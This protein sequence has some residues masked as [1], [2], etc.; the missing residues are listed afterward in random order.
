MLTDISLA[1]QVK[2]TDDVQSGDHSWTFSS[3]PFTLS[4]RHQ[5]SM[6]GMGSVARIRRVRRLGMGSCFGLGVVVVSSVEGI[7]YPHWDRHVLESA[8]NCVRGI[9]H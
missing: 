5:W 9:L 4:K 6:A 1:H 2:N 3:H 7:L 8:E